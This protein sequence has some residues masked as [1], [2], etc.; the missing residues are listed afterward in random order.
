MQFCVRVQVPLLA[1][2]DNL[3][4]YNKEAFLELQYEIKEKD[5]CENV[6]Q[7]LKNQFQLSDRLL[8]RLK[9]ANFIFLNNIPISIKEQVKFGDSIKVQID[10]IEDNSNIVPNEIKLSILFEDEAFLILDKPAN[11]AVH[12]SRMH[13]SDSLS[14]GVRYYFDN[15]NLQKKIRPVNR[16]D[17]DTSR[18]SYFC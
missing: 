6:Q 2:Q 14:N 9:K 3:I 10:F 8:T 15:I 18:I 16:L 13:Y 1:P 11:M 4:Y 12:P 17:K 7:V 5:T